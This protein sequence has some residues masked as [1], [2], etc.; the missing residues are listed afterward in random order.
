MQK[1]LPLNTQ[2]NQNVTNTNYLEIIRDYLGSESILIIPDERIKLMLEITNYDIEETCTM[3]LGYVIHT[4]R[5]Q[6]NPSQSQQ[7]LIKRYTDLLNV[8]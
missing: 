5:L 2:Q 8:R 1:P 6:P 4:L 3:S 7:H